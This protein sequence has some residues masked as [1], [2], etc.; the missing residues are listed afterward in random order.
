MT[1]RVERREEAVGVVHVTV[2]GK[3]KREKIDERARDNSGLVGVQE[4]LESFPG[5]AS[6]MMVRWIRCFRT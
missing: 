2:W 6:A 3:K 5:I 1:F 4:V